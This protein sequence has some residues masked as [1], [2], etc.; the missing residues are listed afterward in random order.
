MPES[1]YFLSPGLEI[2]ELSSSRFL[3][4]S[5]FVAVELSSD[6]A[7]AFVRRA[8]QTL[9]VPQTLDE[10]HSRLPEYDRENL[11]SQ[12]D[13][14]VTEGVLS[15]QGSDAATNHT[16]RSFLDQIGLE[17]DATLERLSKATVAIIGLEAH[18]AHLAQ[19]LASC[20]V[21]RLV[22][23]DQDEFQ[24][25]HLFL[26]P[27][28]NAGVTGRP[29]QDA[30]AE[31]LLS[32]SPSRIETSEYPTLTRD[33]VEDA[34]RKSDLV[35]ACVD[36]GLAAANH[37]AN[38]AAMASST[39]ALFSELRA[40]SSFAGPF[41]EPGRSACWMCYRMRSL[42]CE[43][44]FELAFSYEEH[45]DKKRVAGFTKR[46]ML[47]GLPMQLASTL[48]FEA[49]KYLTGLN[50]PTT[51]NNVLEFDA[52]TGRSLSHP[53]LAKPDCPVCSKKKPGFSQT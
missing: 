28:R 50:P 49:L 18:G 11:K 51:V 45:L 20:G 2:V 16:F 5:D 40:S 9:E 46:P 19:I 6:Q 36:R 32:T 3:L 31:L 14:L 12:L 21:G 27:V 7:G 25:E 44:D 1:E 29:R 47:P 26:T 22:L 23:V 38:Q 10:I 52:L 43:Q 34:T 35:L 8:L 53:V 37:W 48:G 41:L 39:P 24:A 42:A 15:L 13:S 4:R 17:A 30:I 33:C